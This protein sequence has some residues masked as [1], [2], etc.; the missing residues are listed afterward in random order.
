MTNVSYPQ[1]TPP[2][3]VPCARNW[4][5]DTVDPVETACAYSDED[6]FLIL[7]G[8]VP[9][10]ET[11]GCVVRLQELL[12]DP[13]MMTVTD[14]C[15]EMGMSHARLARLCKSIYGATPKAL[16]RKH[17]LSRML[18]VLEHRPYGEWRQFLDLGYVDQSHFI[19][20]FKSFLGMPP[21]HYLA[22]RRHSYA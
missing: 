9:K 4:E 6:P 3:P 5:G 19:R 17:R 14:L 15:A 11:N 12:R 10:A 2:Q 20:E 21:T 8:A 7:L 13:D 22:Q 18:R 1:A 16:L